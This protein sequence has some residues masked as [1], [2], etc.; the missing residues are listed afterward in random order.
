M[1]LIEYSR[2][3]E[4]Y[5][6][7]TCRLSGLSVCWPV[8]TIPM[9]CWLVT[10]SWLCYCR[11]PT[12]LHDCLQLAYTTHPNVLRP[13]WN[14]RYKAKLEPDTGFG[15][16]HRRVMTSWTDSRGLVSSHGVYLVGTTDYEGDTKE[17]VHRYPAVVPK[18]ITTNTIQGDTGVELD[19]K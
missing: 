5:H 10:I 13:Q 9:L 15:G 19:A 14:K 18:R 12:R 11:G 8:I 4:M 17:E 3:M 2:C 1:G 7:A 16:K 6:M